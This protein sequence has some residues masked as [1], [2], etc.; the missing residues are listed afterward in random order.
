MANSPKFRAVAFAALLMLPVAGSPVLAEDGEWVS[1]KEIL[2]GTVLQLREGPSTMFSAVG[3]V[4]SG[5]R[6]VKRYQC[7]DVVGD[8]WCEVEYLGTRG[9]VPM[10]Y[11]TPELR[12]FA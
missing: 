8:R 7:A 9:W 4:P 5:A 10:F 2:P 12:M 1:T 11:L 3:V 6:H